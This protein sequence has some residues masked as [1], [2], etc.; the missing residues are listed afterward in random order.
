MPRWLHALT[1]AVLFCVFGYGAYASAVSVTESMRMASLC[2]SVAA[3]IAC[4]VCAA[5]FLFLAVNGPV[6]D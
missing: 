4:V 1:Y 6:L 5:F 3:F 2:F